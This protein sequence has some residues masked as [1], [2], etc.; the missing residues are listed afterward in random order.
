VQ[1]PHLSPFR[2]IKIRQESPLLVTSSSTRSKH[3]TCV[4]FYGAGLCRQNVYP[5]KQLPR[6]IC[7]DCRRRSVI[8]GPSCGHI[9]ET[10]QDR[11]KVAMKHYYE[12]GIA[13]SVVAFT[14][15]VVRYSGFK[16]NIQAGAVPRGGQGVRG[17]PVK[18]LPPP[19][20]APPLAK[21]FC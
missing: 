15:G 5:K 10:E 18:F 9:L 7:D 4:K 14:W 8:R 20:V 11:P 12:A 16:Y 19:P 1:P 2:S 3:P 21:I 13:D 17:P 6:Q